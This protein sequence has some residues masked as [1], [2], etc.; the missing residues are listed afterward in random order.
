M[1]PI[2]GCN[3]N[4]VGAG[5]VAVDAKH[6]VFDPFRLAPVDGHCLCHRPQGCSLGFRCCL[7]AVGRGATKVAIAVPVTFILK[8]LRGLE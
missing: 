1:L 3:A 4:L 2:L 6:A 5:A 8:I 7:P